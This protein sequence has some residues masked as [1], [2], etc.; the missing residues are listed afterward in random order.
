MEEQHV[1]AKARGYVNVETGTIRDNLPM[2]T[3]NLHSG[4][5]IIGSYSR[6]GVT[7]VLMAKR[8]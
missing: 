6:V 8:L 2:L 4:Y 3:L 1:W 7:R 5:E